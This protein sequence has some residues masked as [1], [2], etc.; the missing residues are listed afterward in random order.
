MQAP[1][2]SPWA[3]RL[4]YAGLIPFLGLAAALWMARPGTE[5]F[6]SAA[7]LAYGATI[8]SFLGAIHWGLLMRSPGSQSLPALAWGVVPCLLGWVAWLLGP[9]VGL[10]LI[11]LLLW[12]CLAV[13][14]VVYPRHQVQAWLP[15]RL[16]LTL[17][18]SGSCVSG[19]LALRL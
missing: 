5:T 8:T 17:V 2:P 13:D 1:N 19:A 3:V 12:A 9:A 4:G 15:M 18:A 10:V 7:L 11:A 14:R 16:W 6:A